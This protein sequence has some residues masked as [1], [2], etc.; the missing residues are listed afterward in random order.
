[1]DDFDFLLTNGNIGFYNQC[2]VIEIFAIN[3]NTKRKFN[4]F[5]LIIFEYTQQPKLE[6]FLTKKLE[7]FKKNKGIKWGIKR[8]IISLQKAKSVFND[9]KN[10]NLFKITDEINIGKLQFQSKQYAQPNDLFIEPQINNVLKNNF[11]S[12]SYIVEGF[13][14]TKEN[15]SFLLDNP[16]QLNAFSEQVSKII[17]ISIGSISDRLGNVIFQFPINIFK[18]Q[19][20]VLGLNKGIQLDFS[21]NSK[22]I[23]EPE[24]QMIIQNKFDDMIL[25]Y[26]VQDIKNKE[27]I[28]INTSEEVQFQIYNKENNL[29]VH[30][31]K[32]TTIKSVTLSVGI[33]SPQNRFFTIGDKEHRI[34]VSHEQPTDI[35]GE[36]DEECK[37][38]I[39]NRKYDKELKRLEQLKSFIQYKGSGEDRKKAL[40]DIR[41][42]IRQHGRSGVYLWDPYLFATDIKQT[43]YFCKN[44]NVE[45]KAI[46]IKNHH[47]DVKEFERDDKKYLLLN[48]EV[49]KQ[50]GN[51]G[52]EFHDRF[53]I[54]PLEKPKVWSL[55]TS[56]HSL[57]NAHHI[58]QEV[59]HAQHILNA[60]NELWNELN[61][62]DC[63]VWKSI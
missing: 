8:H 28:Y 22:L 13:D 25:D 43:L 47:T 11:H 35:I 27:P 42:L 48:L 62:K 30:K 63:L 32:F 60:F 9:L 14:N 49:R 34:S 24:L 4:I 39:D 37:A 16:K 2:E 1:M 55:G 52:S 20:L 31:N 51:Y 58:M 7:Q 33:I 18:L 5:T 50:H 59:Q 45:L 10:K 26:R 6:E 41:G 38:W 23:K 29:I 46:T 3:Q 44:T 36:Q 40:N 15:I 17:P 21:F 12:G 19:M 54:F 56:V 61:H 57:G 53:L